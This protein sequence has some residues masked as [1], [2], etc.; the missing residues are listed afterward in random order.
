MLIQLTEN[1][2]DAERLAAENSNNQ[3]L[4]NITR[5]IGST[6]I[7]GKNN[8]III[9]EDT[10][11]KIPAGPINPSTLFGGEW[12]LFDKGFKTGVTVKKYG[13]T[14]CLSSYEVISIR[15]GNS[16]RFRI[17]LTTSKEINDNSFVLANINLAD[18]GLFNDENGYFPYGYLG[19]VAMSDGGQSVI[20]IEL[21]AGGELKTNDVI[22]DDNK[23]N[24]PANSNFKFECTVIA[25]PSQMLDE[26]CDKFYWRRIA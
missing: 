12:E 18:H 14:D 8:G 3:F 17:N 16:V 9:D 25:T 7:G 6:W 15:G 24:M 20:Q 4:Q 5:P 23:H 26:F 1:M 22:N 19:G 10:G 11:E 13:A 21:G 2:T